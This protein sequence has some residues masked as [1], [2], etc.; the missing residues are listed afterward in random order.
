M[1]APSV[2]ASFFKLALAGERAGF[3]L[4]QMIELLNAGVSVGSLLAL[5]EWELTDRTLPCG[6]PDDLSS[7]RWIM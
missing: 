6:D 3:S 7:S 5:I 1:A 2:A 4:E